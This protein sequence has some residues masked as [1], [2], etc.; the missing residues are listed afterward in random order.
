MYVF[1]R[2]GGTI[3]AYKIVPDEIDD[4]KVIISHPRFS[5]H[6]QTLTPGGQLFHRIQNILHHYYTIYILLILDTYL[7]FTCL[8]LMYVCGLYL[9]DSGGLVR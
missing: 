5:E 9:G 1:H 8:N 3:S 7:Y 6:M 4:I 2:L